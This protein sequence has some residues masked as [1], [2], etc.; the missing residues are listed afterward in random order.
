MA[1]MQW[2]DGWPVVINPGNKEVLYQYPR[3]KTDPTVFASGSMSL[4]HQ[5]FHDHFDG[6]VL[7]SR[8]TFLQN[9]FKKFYEVKKGKLWIDLLPTACNEQKV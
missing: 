1:P 6:T 4:Q 9:T 8:Y 7:N 5:L 3:P 2:I